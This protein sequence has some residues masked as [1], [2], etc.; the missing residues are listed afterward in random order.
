MDDIYD[1]GY[2]DSQ[3]V[4][5]GGTG[6]F[7]YDFGYG[8]TGDVSVGQTGD[9]SNPTPLTVTSSGVNSDFLSRLFSGTMTSG[10]KAGAMLGLGALAIAQSLA[11][12]PP[13][14]KQPVY[15]QAPVYNRALTAPMYGMGYLD[16][17]TN[18][19]VGMGMPLFFNPNPFQFDPTEAAKKYG[20]TPEEIAAGQ[21]VYTQKLSELYTPRSV[22]DVQMTGG[23]KA[24][25]TTAANT[26]VTKQPSQQQAT[27]TMQPAQ[28]QT[29]A[30]RTSVNQAAQTGFL[31][32]VKAANPQLDWA[33]YNPNKMTMDVDPYQQAMNYYRQYGKGIPAAPN[34]ASS[35]MNF[36]LGQSSPTAAQT[37]TQPDSGTVVTGKSGGF[38]QGRG[39]GMSDSI[40]ATINDKQPARLA[41]GEFVVPADVVAHLGNGSSKAGAQRL[42]E[43]M[44][45]VRK[46]RTGTTKQAPEIKA[47][48]FV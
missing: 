6:G 10:D 32:A 3:D 37:T 8:N 5:T 36:Y 13:A 15:K 39:D 24:D 18:K 17:R 35:F 26:P 19:Q 47:E 34:D 28:Q 41:D 25:T 1:F 7:N 16:Q 45:R 44:A 29:E 46:A 48:K 4:S 14:I 22:P 27:V 11:N 2:G 33:N 12:K 20:P 30:Y 31:D 38:L 21:Q 42:Y 9:T 43:M 23:A 40:P